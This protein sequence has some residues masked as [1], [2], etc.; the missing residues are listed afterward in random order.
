M[1]LHIRRLALPALSRLAQRPAPE[2]ALRAGIIAC[3]V[4]A[5]LLAITTRSLAG[6]PNDAQRIVGHTAPQRT[7]PA[8]QDGHLLPQPIALAS[9]PGHPILLIFTY[10]LC[11]HCLGETQA[12]QQ[13]QQRY[14]A[15]GLYVTYIDSP[16]EATS[17]VSAYQQRLN[18]ADPMLLDAG[19]TLADRFGL[20][21]YPATVLIDAHGVVRHVETG[22]TSL[23]T[24]RHDIEEM[25]R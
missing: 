2:T 8:V 16:A 14:T 21:Y 6:S 15:R 1:T 3:A 13:L 4:L 18:L 19:G 25:V 9:H 20:H 5:L 22:E 17:I 11:P 23:Q 7:L 12:I 24:L 10:S